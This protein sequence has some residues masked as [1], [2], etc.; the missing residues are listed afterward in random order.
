MKAGKA[1]G[2]F[3][4]LAWHEPQRSIRLRI[5]Q[6]SPVG[7]A[8][9]PDLK[10][11]TAQKGSAPV[12]APDESSFAQAGNWRVVVPPGAV[13]G[14]SDMILRVDYKGDEARL[15]NGSHLL[16]DNFYNGTEWRIG[17]K[18]FLDKGT[19]C[20]LTLQVLPLSKEAP[21]F[22]D[23]GKSPALGKDGQAGSLQSIQA[24]PEY[25]IEMAF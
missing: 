13:N 20:T 22:F 17:M 3:Q 16:T 11:D 19:A 24:L 8:P 4:H 15:M 12:Q 6:T 5:E 10:T 1:A 23:N 7:R 14:L 9:S 18:R 21:I 2:L 25:E